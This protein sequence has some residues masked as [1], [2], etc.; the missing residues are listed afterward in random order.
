MLRIEQHGPVTVFRM[1]RHVANRR[2]VLYEA[3]AFLIDETMIDTGTIAV[4]NEWEPKLDGCRCSTIVNTHHHED[5]IGN[6]R[7][8]QAR[9]GAEIYAH[10][11]ALAFLEEPRRIGMQLYRRVVWN[12]PDPSRGRPV[13][14]TVSTSPVSYTH[15]TLPTTPYV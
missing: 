9:F 7:L 15:L 4:R 5:H 13:G 1:G 12:T 2:W 14:D 11:G 6:N 3:H 10:P 8:F